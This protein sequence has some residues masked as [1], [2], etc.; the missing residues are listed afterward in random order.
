MHQIPTYKQYI[1]FETAYSLHKCCLHKPTSSNL[2][3]SVL[4]LKNV[5]V[6]PGLCFSITLVA[7]RCCCRIFLKVWWSYWVNIPRQKKCTLQEW[8]AVKYARW[9]V[10]AKDGR[11]VWDCIQVASAAVEWTST[12]SPCTH[13][14]PCTLVYRPT[15]FITL[16]RVYRVFTESISKCLKKYVTCGCRP[17]CIFFECKRPDLCF[18]M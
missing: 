8:L 16:I 17:I 12:C 9:W 13:A 5:K 10:I 2:R 6:T 18:Q 7:Q 1:N 14:M 11:A 3:P 4:S 15:F